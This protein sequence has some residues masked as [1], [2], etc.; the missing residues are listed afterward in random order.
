MSAEYFNAAIPEPWT[1]LGLRLRPFGGGHLLLLQRLE[2]GFVC[3]GN[4]DLADLVTSVFICSRTFEQARDA[5][6]DED[7]PKIINRW[8]RKLIGPWW[9]PTIVNFPS[10]IGM[11]QEYITEGC[12]VPEYTSR[13]DGGSINVPTVQF[14]KAF[15]MTKTSIG[16]SEFYNRPWA[17][18]MWDV[19]TIQA[20]EGQITL[21]DENAI[22]DAQAV[23]NR[24][25]ELVKSGQLKPKK[26]H[27]TA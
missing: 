10:K 19:L 4:V 13:G 17:L 25:A 14:V 3:G 12:R 27:G 18:S 1:I 24:L 15:L 16:E 21:T 20:M 2:S 8:H 23:A 22:R 7:L 9:N 11:F 6:Q 26:P 5:L